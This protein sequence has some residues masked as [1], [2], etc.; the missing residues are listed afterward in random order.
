MRLEKQGRELWLNREEITH[1]IDTI[2]VI[3]GLESAIRT[4]QLD[5]LYLYNEPITVD[6]LDLM[7]DKLKLLC[8]FHEKE[9]S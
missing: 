1:I 2:C 5:G 9:L 8:G 3:R 4:N 6:H 7:V